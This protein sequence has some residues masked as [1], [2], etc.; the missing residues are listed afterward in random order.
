MRR[1]RPEQRRL[2]LHMGMGKTGSSALQVAFVRNREKLADAGVNYPEH[3][4]DEPARRGEVISGNGMGITPYLAPPKHDEEEAARARRRLFRTVEDSPQETVLYSS[5]FLYLFEPP[6]L[7][8]LQADMRAR[9]VVIQAVVY[10]RDVAGHALSSYSQVVKRALYTG[11]FADYL[12]SQERLSYR[13]NLRPRLRRLRATLGPENVLV[14]HYDTTRERLFADFMQRVFGI[15]DLSGFDL[16][17]GQVNRSLTRHELEMMRYMNGF[18]E[19]KG[20]A[21]RVS[22][23]LLEQPPLGSFDMT[24]TPK[25]LDVLR[26][27]FADEV[28]WVNS[29]L[30]T[31]GLLTIEGGNIHVVDAGDEFELS[32]V[33]RHL[34]QCLVALVSRG[35]PST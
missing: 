3:S 24:I 25:E 22:D 9:D 35:R 33:E 29:E 10:V 17:T 31:D 19:R 5:E 30:L 15:S 11:A 8:E 2:V 26:E 13:L 27:R 12:T 7:D 34:L 18:L 21:R 4:S 20:Q 32:Q 28:E 1:V 16:C 23:V 6:R 14:I